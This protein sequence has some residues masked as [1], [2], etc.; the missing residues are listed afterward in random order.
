MVTN[1]MFQLFRTLI[2]RQQRGW[3]ALLMRTEISLSSEPS[4][5]MMLPMHLTCLTVFSSVPS[6]VIVGLGT[7]EPGAGWNR[8]SY[9]RSESEC[10]MRAQSSANSASRISR[11]VFLDVAFC[12]WRSKR[13]LSSLY[14]RYTPLLSPCRAC[15]RKNKLRGVSTYPSFTLF[16]LSN[17]SETCLH[18]GIEVHILPSS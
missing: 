14:R 15:S 7:L 6:M 12:L 1:L 2:C 8:R 10:T 13:E 18:S 11:L 3:L 9:W 17:E 16:D 5:E 4:E